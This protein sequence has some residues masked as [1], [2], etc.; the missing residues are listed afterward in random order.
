MFFLSATLPGGTLTAEGASE[1]VDDF[2]LDL[3]Q[4]EQN[5][6]SP[7][8]IL[9]PQKEQKDMLQ[10]FLISGGKKNSIVPKKER[11]GLVGHLVPTEGPKPF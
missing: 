6:H 4:A 7:W 10:A 5:F 3:P 11:V 8:P 9:C 1:G 2:T